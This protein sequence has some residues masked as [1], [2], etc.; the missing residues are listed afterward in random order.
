M[1]EISFDITGELD[2]TQDRSVKAPE[3]GKKDM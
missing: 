1:E 3:S 2:V